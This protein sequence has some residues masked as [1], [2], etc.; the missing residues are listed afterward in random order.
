MPSKK[1]EL[2][3]IKQGWIGSEIIVSYRK[4]IMSHEAITKYEDVYQMIKGV[5]DYNLINLQEQFMAFYLN[6]ANRLI[7]YR[8]INTGSMTQC[9]IDIKLVVSLAL[10]SMATAV[11][12]AHDHPSGSLKPSQQD[13]IV[14]TRIK[15][16]LQLIDVR[17]LDHFII[18]E[19]AYLCFQ[20][21]GLI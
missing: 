4:V 16:A 12:L 20:E 11:I 1:E 2:K 6:S 15:S 13:E 21:Q 5:W 17:L 7:G 10:H 3:N 19:E 9:S 8:L 18:T 14:T